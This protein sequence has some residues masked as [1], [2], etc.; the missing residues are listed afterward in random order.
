MDEGSIEKNIRDLITKTPHLSLATVSENRPWVCEVH[1]A[2]DEQLNLYFVS[3]P[4]TRHCR[5]IENNN[6]VAGN[7]IK[8]HSLSEAPKG[9]YFEGFAQMIEASDEDIERY[10]TSLRRNFEQ[11]KT[12]LDEENGRRMYR[13]VVGNWAVFGDIDGSG[14]AKRELK[15]ASYDR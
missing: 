11:I 9:L 8:Q 12:Q 7:I 1:F 3:K 4:S 14:H 15:W 10:A 2:Y 13:I 6:N 5:E